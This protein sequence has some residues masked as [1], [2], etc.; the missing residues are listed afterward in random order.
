VD[1][2]DIHIEYDEAFRAACSGGHM[3]IAQWLYH[4]GGVDI[5]SFDEQAFR[6]A[7]VNN[8][9]SVAQWLYLG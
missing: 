1:V 6:G 8:H 5:H 3:S 7:C 2:I 9:L 4:Q